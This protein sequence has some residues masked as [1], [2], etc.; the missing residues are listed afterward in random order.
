MGRM[1]SI[2][3]CRAV[4]VIGRVCND[5][6]TRAM[7]KGAQIMRILDRR[8]TEMLAFESAKADELS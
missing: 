7:K 6:M 8:V 3:A 2:G 1:S 5:T 4:K